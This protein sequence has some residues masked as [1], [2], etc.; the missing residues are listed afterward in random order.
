MS[1][2]PVAP[3]T[4]WLTVPVTALLALPI[5][6]GCFG[7]TLIFLFTGVF[8]TG[9]G[10]DTGDDTA[11][12]GWLIVRVSVAGAG[13]LTGVFL[14]TGD[15][16]GFEIGFGAALTAGFGVEAAGFGVVAIGTGFFD[17]IADRTGVFFTGV[18]VE[19]PFVAAGFL[20]LATETGFFV[21]IGVRTGVLAAAGDAVFAGVDIGFFTAGLGVV[22]TGLIGFLVPIGVLGLA[23]VVFLIL[24]IP[25]T[26]C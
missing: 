25:A 6:P 9:V 7:I 11:L 22:P 3:E 14:T 2:P 12:G 1:T 8:F 15:G 13:L 20:V 19:A 24:S 4:P 17:P 18:S 21:P 23:G 26:T 5:V 10:L 16:A